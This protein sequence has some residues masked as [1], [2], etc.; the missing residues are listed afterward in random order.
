MLYNGTKLAYVSAVLDSS[1]LSHN[2]LC[3]ITHVYIKHIVY[4][5]TGTTRNENDNELL[6]KTLIDFDQKL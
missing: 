1:S 2:L 5:P 6:P 3:H 4:T